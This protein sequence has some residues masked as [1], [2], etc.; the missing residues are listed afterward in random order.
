MK[1]LLFPTAGNGNFRIPYVCLPVC[2]SFC[3][4][5]CFCLSVAQYAHLFVCLPARCDC[6]YVFGACP[7]SSPLSASRLHPSIS[8]S[9]H[10]LHISFV[11]V[12]PSACTSTYIRLY[13]SGASSRRVESG[14][15][16]DVSLI[17]KERDAGVD[18]EEDRSIRA[19]CSADNQSPTRGVA[20][21]SPKCDE[22][23]GSLGG[24]S[25]G[26]DCG[27]GGSGGVSRTTLQRSMDERV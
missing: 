8:R 11:S 16:V 24:C 9:V 23:K 27:D 4:F 7:M 14:I 19:S 5:I 15:E 12:S 2:R 3:L 25:C 17:I 22:T 21:S 18:D 26:C 6:P 13:V 20:P 1:L 10:Y